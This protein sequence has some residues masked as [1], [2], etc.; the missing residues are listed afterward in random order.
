ML[1]HGVAVRPGKPTLAAR[2]GSKLLIGLPGHPTSCLLNMHWL[3]LPV[4]RRLARLPGPGW[5]E[6]EV[7]LAG[8]VA[9]PTA[10][11]ATVVPLRVRGDRAW[12]TFRG[13]SLL[14]SLR[15]TAGFTILP[16]GR[17]PRPA[18]SLVR[19]CLLD[20]PLGPPTTR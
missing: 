7:R 2:A 3:V 13:S 20:P 9:P 17:G 14:S 11:F 18:G 5:T 10:G 6:R 8:P 19:A 12:S 4:L 15:E 1:F 16:P